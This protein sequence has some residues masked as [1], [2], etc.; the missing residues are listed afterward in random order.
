MTFTEVH[1]QIDYNTVWGQEMKISLPDGIHDM[2]NDGCG[3]WYAEVKIASGTGCSYRYILF[4]EGKPEKNEDGLHSIKL[5]NTVRRYTFF[6]RW[7]DGTHP[8]TETRPIVLPYVRNTGKGVWKGAGTAVPVFSLRSGSSF[9]IGEFKDLKLLADWA[10]M[11]GQS[12]IQILPVNDTISTRSWRDS[13]PYNCISSFALNPMYLNIEELG[14][15]TPGQK[16]SYEYARRTLDKEPRID[17]EHVMRTKFR[18][19]RTCYAQHGEETLNSREFKEF[20]NM[21]QE[22]L[23]PYCVYCFKRDRTRTTDFNQWGSKLKNADRKHIDELCSPENRLYK[24]VM[25]YA[26]LQFHLDRQLRDAKEYLNSRGILLK[27]DVPIGIGRKSV[28]VWHSPELFNTGCQAG[29]PPD[30]FSDDGQKWGFP[31]YNWPVMEQDGYRWFVERFR[32][33]ARHFDAY[34]IDHLLGFFRIWEI[35]MKYDSGLMGRF[36]PSLP[37]SVK[38]LESMGY[39]FDAKRDTV[40]ADPSDPV[41]LLFLEYEKAGNRYYPRIA[42]YSTKA[43]RRLSKELQDAYCRIHEDFYYRRH[44]RFWEES[45]MRKLPAI[46]S[47]TEMLCCGEDLGMIPDCVPQVM[48]KLRILSLEIQRM[49]KEFGA[50]LGD[51]SKYPY[52]SVCTTSSHDMDGIRVWIEEEGPTDESGRRPE[53][54]PELCR[55]ILEE[56]LASPSMLA[57]FPIQDWLSI[58]AE[59]RSGD[60][61]EE[62]INVPSNPDNVWNY[63]MHLDLETLIESTGFNNRVK[64]MIEKSGR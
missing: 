46:V 49:P 34:R 45:A 39:P 38:E 31:T 35:P 3:H 52:M 24:G 36:N 5:K 57:V 56:H 21:N 60:P 59:L 17:V 29:A 1:F 41:D 47:S 9:G 43:Y 22:W 61:R 64:E 55:R 26:Y 6:D 40:P 50:A 25:L 42:G 62:R 48:E 13:Y 27:G 23:K 58:D 33:M 28:D 14:F 16:R 30:D 32:R 37:Y 4:N 44:S 7:I 18:Y 63:R 15:T 53:A 10:V 8:E 20:Y 54:T 2:D 19:F 12:V 11:T 51:P